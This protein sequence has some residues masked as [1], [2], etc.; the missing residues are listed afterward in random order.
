MAVCEILSLHVIQYKDQISISFP[1]D[2]MREFVFNYDF[3]VENSAKFMA[4]LQKKW[5]GSLEQMVR[6]GFVH[7]TVRGEYF[8]Y[9]KLEEFCK[10]NGIQYKFTQELL[11]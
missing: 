7:T 11:I 9:L 4:A 1:L 3:D 5:Q 10:K 2:E 8:E 6:E